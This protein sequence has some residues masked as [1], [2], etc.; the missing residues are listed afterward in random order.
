M[1]HESHQESD[2]TLHTV[3]AAHRTVSDHSKTRNC[4]QIIISIVNFVFHECRR[5]TCI[6]SLSSVHPRSEYFFPQQAAYSYLNFSTDPLEAPE[7]LSARIRNSY[8]RET[9]C[10]RV[11]NKIK[12]WFL[13]FLT[14][15]SWKL[16]GSSCRSLIPFPF[17]PIVYSSILS[18]YSSYRCTNVVTYLVEDEVMRAAFTGILR[19]SGLALIN[20]PSWSRTVRSGASI[21]PML[22]RQSFEKQTTCPNQNFR[23]RYD[24]NR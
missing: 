13:R 2:G 4:A 22:S 15:L 11:F 14:Y 12:E 5:R 3:P 23:P 10:Q 20:R 19:G 18:R 9:L 7:S 21:K 6:S 24:F 17:V 16:W 8:A 1:S